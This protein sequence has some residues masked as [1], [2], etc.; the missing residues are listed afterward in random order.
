MGSACRRLLSQTYKNP[1]RTGVHA[2]D[3][4]PRPTG[5][6]CLLTCISYFG[7]WQSQSNNTEDATLLPDAAPFCIND[8]LDPVR[9]LPAE[10]LNIKVCIDML[11][12]AS[13]ARGK[14]CHCSEMRSSTRAL[15]GMQYVRTGSC[16]SCSVP[17]AAVEVWSCGHKNAGLQIAL[18]SW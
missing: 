10:I 6:Q 17:L 18:V 9:Q 16:W 14:L 5:T 13:H 15:F 12:D 11:N 3:F 8:I 7:H 4:Y 1:V 2:S